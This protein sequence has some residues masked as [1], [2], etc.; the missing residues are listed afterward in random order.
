MYEKLEVPESAQSEIHD[1]T[2]RLATVGNPDFG[3]DPSRPMFGVLNKT[4]MTTTLKDASQKCLAYIAEHDI[5]GGNWVGGQVKEY[6]K[7]V[8][9]IGY[10]GRVWYPKPTKFKVR[11]ENGE[12][13]TDEENGV[14][15]DVEFQTIKDAVIGAVTFLKEMIESG[16]DY[17]AR[18]IEIVA[19]DDGDIV[20][21]NTLELLPEILGRGDA[22]E[23]EALSIEDRNCIE[24]LI[25]QAGKGLR[26]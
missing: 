15:T 16:L 17:T 25:A 7:I 14:Q 8:A 18:D 24:D 10:N 3:Q 6:G 19:F 1:Y 5:G 26:P 21:I 20:S 12:F 23:L 2:V 11:I 22:S 13:W 4:I 9:K